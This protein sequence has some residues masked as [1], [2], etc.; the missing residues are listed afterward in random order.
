MIT[1][2]FK[3]SQLHGKGVYNLPNGD[4]YDGEWIKG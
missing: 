1:G 3:D 4:S 2:I